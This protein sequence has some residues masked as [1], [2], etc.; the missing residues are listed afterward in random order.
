MAFAATV[1]VS[2]AILSIVPW[3][4]R[5]LSPSDII[6]TEK[7]R[8]APRRISNATPP[9]TEITMLIR[10]AQVGTEQNAEQFLGRRL[11][12]FAAGKTTI[13]LDSFIR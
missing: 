12:I 4:C 11:S 3:P 13:F 8:R 2:I 10:L 5:Y 7:A 1:H 6:S 9:P